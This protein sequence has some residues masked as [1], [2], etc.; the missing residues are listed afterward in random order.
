MKKLNFG[1]GR[2]IREGWDNCDKQ[3]GQGIITFSADKFPYPMKDNTY[4]FILLKQ[5]LDFVEDVR[6]TLFELHRISKPNGII[7][8]EVPY[9]NN[10]GAFNDIETKHFFSD[11]TFKIFVDEFCI[12]DR[13]Y[14]FRI[15]ELVLTPTIVGKCLPKCLRNK[16]SMFIPGLISQI[17]IELEVIK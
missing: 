3:K 2:D 17:H 10:R 5:V 13:L 7:R 16:L 14:K 12:V 6:K 4:D 9:Y 1:C 11:N 8:I 15:D